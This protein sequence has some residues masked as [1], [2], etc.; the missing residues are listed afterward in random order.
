MSTCLDC[1]NLRARIP[2]VGKGNLFQ[3]R[4]FYVGALV[5]CREGEM[6]LVQDRPRI[7]KNVFRSTIPRKNF[8]KAEV[9]MSFE[10]E[11]EE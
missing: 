6:E 10:G 9:C 2:L 8:L 4:L 7:F 5:W 11:E 1:F 3:K